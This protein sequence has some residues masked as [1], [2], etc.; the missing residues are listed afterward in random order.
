MP[1]GEAGPGTTVPGQAVRRRVVVVGSANVDLVVEVARRPAAGEMLLGSDLVTAPGGK[2]ANHAVAA[3]VRV[4]LHAAPA[5]APD[6]S[7]LEVCDPLV[8]NETEATIVLGRPQTDPVTPDAVRDL[9]ATGPRSVVV[10]AGGDGSF[11]ARA[12]TARDVLHVPAEAVRA[13]DTTGA[14]DAYV[15][16]MAAAL[17][18]GYPLE[19]AVRAATR[20][21]GLSVQRRGAKE[22]YPRRSDLGPGRPDEA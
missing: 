12:Q 21:A 19:R 8:V 7:V 17:A 11:L 13:V 15:G 22:S 18:Q 4:V 16:A 1:P 14:G 20:A 9:L 5:A 10:T 6:R 2:G 3:G